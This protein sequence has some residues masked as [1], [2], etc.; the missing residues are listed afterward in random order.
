MAYVSIPLSALE[1]PEYLSLYWAHRE[2]LIA[3]YV[4]HNDAERFSIACNQP[5]TYRMKPGVNL[6]R[7]IRALMDSGLIVLDGMQAVR[8][9]NA[10]GGYCFHRRVFRFKYPAFQLEQA[11]A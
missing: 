9:R 2:F 5:Q 4:E 6:Q 3:L 8:G 1:S 7:R 11:A 10:T